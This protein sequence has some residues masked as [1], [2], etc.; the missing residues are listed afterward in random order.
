MRVEIEIAG[1][2]RLL[3]EADQ[4]WVHEQIGNRQRAGHA[5][6]VRVYFT[7][8]GL[9]FVLSTPSSRD[10]GGQRRASPEELPFVELWRKRGLD[11]EDFTS[12]HVIAFL[13]QLRR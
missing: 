10:R 8:E 7:G 11:Q 4:Q 5:V 6:C 9:D 12:G 1:E 13:Q 3:S 2:R